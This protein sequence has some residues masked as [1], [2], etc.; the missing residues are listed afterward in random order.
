M[1]VSLCCSYTFWKPNQYQCCWLCSK[2]C[3]LCLYKVASLTCTCLAQLGNPLHSTLHTC[4]ITRQ[5]VRWFNSIC[6]VLTGSEQRSFLSFI[7]RSLWGPRCTKSSWKIQHAHWLHVKVWIHEVDKSMF[8]ICVFF[9]TLS[10]SSP[11]QCSTEAQRLLARFFQT[12]SINSYS[13]L[14]CF[15]WW[16]SLFFH[17]MLL[18]LFLCQQLPSVHHLRK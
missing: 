9:C 17:V 14:F 7:T 16:S 15:Y 5:S 12:G 2:D 1:C 6:F 8:Y 13:L 10:C 11:R 4:T 3:C 18:S